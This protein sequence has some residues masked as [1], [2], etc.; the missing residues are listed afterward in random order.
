MYGMLRYACPGFFIL[1][2]LIVSCKHKPLPNQ[3]M[4]DLLELAD[5][6]EYNQENIFSPEAILMFTDSLLNTSPGGN[7]L[8][9]IK[10]RKANALLQLGQEQKAIDVFEDMLKK[11]SPFE[12][13]Q[14]RSIM[15]DLAM[16]YLRL[17]ERTNCFHNHTS[18]S[19]IFPI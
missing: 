2:F 9:K 19:C 6:H 17:G 11:T 15:K 3:E 5:K 7:D 4:I 12:F 16:A 8:V 18:E 13:D 10:F 14:R 1:A